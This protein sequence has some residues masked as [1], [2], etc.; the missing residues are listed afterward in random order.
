MDRQ[1]SC[2][3]EILD[4]FQDPDQL[5]FFAEHNGLCNDVRIQQRHNELSAEESFKLMLQNFDDA[6]D[7]MQF[8]KRNSLTQD[9]D[10]QERLSQL[11]T[12][13]HCCKCFRKYS[14]KS[15]TQ[16]HESNC[17]GLTACS[18]C[19]TVYPSLFPHSC[20]AAIQPHQDQQK[21]VL[22]D[23]AT[24]GTSQ[25]KSIQCSKCGKNFTRN[26]NRNKHEAKCTQ[27]ALS[28]NIEQEDQSIL[29]RSPIVRTQ[30]KQQTTTC[31]KCMRTF[32]NKYYTKIHQ[33]KCF[34]CSECK[35]QFHSQLNLDTHSCTKT[36]IQ[37]KKCL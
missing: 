37:C 27:L 3:D 7:L 22:S 32:R 5:L 20:E 10:V 8:A 34:F 28:H 9:I 15:Y 2:F 19:S 23:G 29:D 21:R 11:K 36:P 35:I 4:S 33:A 6:Y 17:Q 13:N 30:K 12:S 31:E 24:P 18:K 26:S 16:L 25:C 14:R 1:V